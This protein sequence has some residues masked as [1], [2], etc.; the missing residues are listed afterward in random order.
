MQ[1]LYKTLWLCALLGFTGS[2]NAQTDVTNQ[3]LK[4]ADFEGSY[5]IHT[6]Y[7]KDVAKDHRAIY[8]PQDWDVVYEN[9][10]KNDYSVLKEGDL[11]Y[12]SN[13]KGNFIHLDETK[14]GQQTY[15]VRFRWGGS[16]LLKLQQSVVL[17][18]GAYEL[19]ADIIGN[20]Q[21]KMHIFAGDAS[22]SDN[23]TDS[24]WKNVSVTFRSDGTTPIIIGVA[25]ERSKDDQQNGVDNFKLTAVIDKTALNAA[26][27][28]GSD[29]GR[30]Q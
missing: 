30:Q 9:G 2:A 17:P 29:A 5:T 20:S 11:L 15:R 10:D 16:E 19:S 18:A 27:R 14:F 24:K 28:Y 26:I 22:S 8:Q 1:R 21:G 3:Y 13:F 7:S 4:N 23:V 25:F 12:S 6:E